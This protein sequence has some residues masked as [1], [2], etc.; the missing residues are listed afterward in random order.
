MS[1]V[2]RIPT[3]LYKRLEKHAQGFDTPANTIERILDYYESSKESPRPSATTENSSPSSSLEIIYYPSGE[4]NFK[5]AL[6]ESRRAYVLLHMTDG[7]VKLHEWNASRFG[8][9]SDV[10][11]NLRTGYLRKWRDKGI[12]KA[13]VAINKEDIEHEND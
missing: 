7:S 6:L 1:Q 9:N 5:R 13:E 8:K 2:I 10:N 12:F 11:G 4:Q 3:I